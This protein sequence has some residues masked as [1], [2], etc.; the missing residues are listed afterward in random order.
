[1]LPRNFF[2][3]KLTN[4]HKLTTWLHTAS[5]ATLVGI[6]AFASY[7]LVFATPQAGSAGGDAANPT[8][9][10]SMGTVPAD[11][12]EPLTVAVA[13]LSRLKPPVVPVQLTGIVAAARTSQLAAKQL[14]RVEKV[15]VDIGDK[16]QSGQLL[17]E[18]D[19]EPLRAERDILMAHL[20]AAEALLNELRQGPRAQEIA[21]AKSRV[22]E[23]DA[24]LNY[25]QAMLRRSEQ[26]KS[27]NT[28]SQQEYDESYMAF[29]VAGAQLDSHR[30]ALDLLLEGTRQERILAQEATVAAFMAQIAKVDVHLAEQR[31]VAPFPGSVQK[32]WIDEGTVVNPGEAILEI[33]EDEAKEI[34]VGLPTEIADQMASSEVRLCLA[35]K[36]VP[37]EIVRVAPAIDERTRKIE[38]VLRPQLK[39]AGSAIASTNPDDRH[40]KHEAG[41]LWLIGHAVTVEIRNDRVE[42]GLW[43][44]AECLSSGT[45]GLWSIYLAVS[46]PDSS[47]KG[48][49]IAQRCEVEVLRTVGDWVEIGGPVKGDERL[50]VSGIHR[51]TNGQL[52]QVVQQSLSVPSDP[53]AEEGTQ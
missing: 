13:P 43:V 24:N 50:I 52:V 51:L 9:A 28:I 34:H 12:A 30:K 6:A 21:Q 46:Q 29:V 26:L 2:P 17:V 36:S 47:G 41:P 35:G 45:R 18:L 37:G 14:G 16:V 3:Q 53:V 19:V 11:H 25:R 32:R 38:V 20:A 49:S 40:S 10:L 33:V 4:R 7:H 15:H 1:M 48:L 23:A 8:G 42:P 39:P 44:P 22:E 27:I 5:M 31:I